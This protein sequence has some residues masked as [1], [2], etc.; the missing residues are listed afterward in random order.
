MT[1]LQRIAYLSLIL[2]AP[3]C[4]FAQALY[5][6]PVKVLGDP[7][8]TGTASNPLQATNNGPNW[9]E[10]REFSFPLGI[11]VDNSVSPPNIYIADVGN[12]RVL[13]FRYATQL[14][15]GAFADV[16][17]GQIDFIANIAQSAGGRS[18]GMNQPTGLICDNQGNLYVAD[19]GNNRI[20]RY[21]KPLSQPAGLAF[22]DMVIG[23]TSLSGK[24]SN[25]N[26]ISAT[27]LALAV[28]N[29]SNTGLAIDASGNLWVS[30][31]GNN[32]VLRFPVAALQKGQN[33]PAADLVLGQNDFSSRAT[34]VSQRG[35][36][37]KGAMVAPQ[38]L[39][40]D[41][42]GRLLVADSASRVLVYPAGVGTNGVAIRILGVDPT[43]TAA[44]PVSAI[45]VSSPFG[46]TAT[47]AGI[48]VAD[49][50]DHRVLVFPSVDAWP[51]ES[52]QFSPTASSVIGQTSFTQFKANQGL[53]DAS[54]NTLNL[55]V[56]AAFS[57]SEL[58]V[59]DASNNR[60]LVYNAG[61]TGITTTASRVIGQLDFPYTSVNLVEGR[62]FHLADGVTATSALGS[63]VLDQSVSPPRLWVADSLN[64][65]VLGFKDFTRL[66][67][68]DKADIVIGQPDM[69]R[70][71]A[72]YPTDDATKPNAQGLHFPTGLVVDSAGNLFV[73]DTGNSRILRFPAPFDSD[74][75]ALQS[76]DLVLGQATFTS[77]VTDPSERTMSAP[78]GLALT[79]D[80][81]N[82]SLSSGGW[83]IATDLVHNRALFFPRPFSNGMAANK[84]L[85]SLNF[86]STTPG[87]A[88]PPRFNN[89]R[90]VAVDPQDRVIIVDSGNRRIQVFNKAANINNFDTP[91]ISLTGVLNGLPLGVSAGASGFWVNDA[92]QNVAAHYP[93]VDQL[94]L[95][96]NS[97][98]AL[99]PVLAPLSVFQDTF[100]NVLVADGFQRVV[101]YA[102]QVNL[103]SAAN[104]SSRPLTAGSIAAM[105]SAVNTNVL[106]GPTAAATDLPL[107]TT[108]SDTQVLVNGTPAP[109]YFV[110]PGQIN[111][112]LSNSLPGGGTADIQVV[113]VKTGQITGGTELQLASA[114]PAMFT[115]N[116][117]GGGQIVAYNVADG[118]VNSSTNAVARGQYIV[119]YG[120]GV[121]P[122]PNAPADGAAAT[123][124]ISAP[125]KPLIVLGSSSTALPDENVSYSGLA[126][127]LVGVW[128]LNV[129]IPQNAQT[130]S[131]VSVRIFQNSIPSIDSSAA[132]GPTTIA[133]K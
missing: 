22:P 64:N 51:S 29:V 85:G 120:T 95:R 92:T 14:K 1:S 43:I 100:N 132:T 6:K 93:P 94:I 119:L 72:N 21:P 45:S 81:A 28:T 54:A 19:T 42:A 128:Q 44:S 83:L 52:Q 113:R 82:A 101:Y 30:D 90:G 114:A 84:L 31:T 17:L 70:T 49:S 50:A 76:A 98:D 55:P 133:I 75:Q 39:S 89:P 103:I 61:P 112:E 9:T 91:P 27:S 56:Q 16:V 3:T 131:S 58:Y 130:G 36:T 62:E 10:G 74:K 109:L 111:L 65:R 73:A 68:G 127:G 124:A 5:R 107:P 71:L 121:G 116:A 46:V 26:G 118:T 35:S 123:T 110:S 13:G 11:A 77:T 48:V 66:K 105:F 59:A 80:A 63:A 20:L 4:L 129:L 69:F 106:G 96:N 40:F 57:G 41:S 99:L 86:S 2:V 12:S 53:G 125:S 34:T 117:S 8:Y 104:Y 79:A 32:R 47:S 126:P 115:S 25:A 97:A 122:V 78:V 23:Q 88:D 87:S 102:P 37:N 33:G 15:A 18:T 108:L 60:V 7:Q 67:N 24:S 38:G